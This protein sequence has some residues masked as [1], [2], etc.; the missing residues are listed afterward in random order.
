MIDILQN[1]LRNHKDREQKINIAR[2][3]LQLL[4][5]KIIYDHGLFRGM[6]FGGG[7]ALRIIH[8]I[9]RFSEDLDF[10]TIDP[11]HYNGKTLAKTLEGNIKNYGFSANMHFKENRTAHSLLIRF[12]D[13]LFPLKLSPLKNQKIMIKVDIDTNPPLGFQTQLTL[14]NEM[15][16]IFTATHFDLPSLYATKLHACFYRKYVKGRDFYDLIWYLGKSIAPNFVVL[17]NA[18]EQTE[19]RNPKIE[20]GNFK[21]FLNVNLEKIDFRK[22]RQD[23]ERFLIDKSELRLFDLDMIRAAIK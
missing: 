16:F 15:T 22:A 13:I 20:Q 10:S 18:I 19:K 2:E 11:K 1:Q 14:I 8:K 9:R 3:Y 23:V 17:N 4:I 7:T 5:L 6:A 12:A 21:E